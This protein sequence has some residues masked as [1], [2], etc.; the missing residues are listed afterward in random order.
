MCIAIVCEKSR[1]DERLLAEAERQNQDGAGIAW[2]EKG[3]VRFLKGLTAKQVEKEIKKLPFPFFIHFRLA[4]VGGKIDNLCHP[5]AVRRDGQNN[6][7]GRS[8]HVLMHN[9]HWSNWKDM[10]AASVVN[11]NRVL[12]TGPWS[13]T[14]AM[15]YLAAHHGFS[16]LELITSDRI[17][18]MDGKGKVYKYGYWHEKDGMVFSNYSLISIPGS[19]HPYYGTDGKSMGFTM[20]K[21]QRKEADRIAKQLQEKNE[22]R[23]VGIATSRMIPPH[24]RTPEQAAHLVT[25]RIET[26]RCPHCA[27]IFGRDYRPH[28]ENDYKGNNSLVKTPET[29]HDFSKCPIPSDKCPQ[30]KDILYGRKNKNA[31]VVVSKDTGPVSM[32]E[33]LKEINEEAQSILNRGGME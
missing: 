24:E 20:S 31:V 15:A 7:E 2:A 23:V 6:T 18:V 13:D 14:R 4:T 26:S 25:C 3:V 17:A 9:G 27:L 30:C 22:Q 28:P 32:S 33:A 21:K 11:G 12:A 8:S 16:I 1:P 19:S 10:L 5:F 29:S